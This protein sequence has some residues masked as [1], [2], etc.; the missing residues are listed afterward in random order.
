MDDETGK[1]HRREDDPL[2]LPDMFPSSASSSGKSGGRFASAIHSL[3]AS[4]SSL[5]FW[6]RNGASD[7]SS[8]EGEGNAGSKYGS[9][10][11]VPKDGRGDGCDGGSS[12]D[13]DCEIESGTGGRNGGDG[14]GK[15]LSFIG[16]L[17]VCYFLVCGGAYGTEDLASSIPPLFAL[18]GLLVLPWFWSL[19]IALIVAELGSALPS[20]EGFL[21]WIRKAWGEGAAFIDGWIMIITIII[22]QSLY[23]VIFISY[24]ES[25]EELE[26]IQEFAISVGYIVLAMCL[27]LL[28]VS[29]VGN[30]STV[31]TCLTLVPFGIYFIAGFFSDNFDASMWIQTDMTNG[32]E[33]DIALYLSVLV[34]ATCAYE[35]SGFLAGDVRNPRKVF[36]IAMFSVVTMMIVTY[37]LPMAMTIATA[38]HLD[39]VT[40]GS[41]PDLAKDLGVGDWMGWCIVI[42]G[43]AST[44]GTYITY[45]HTSST[46]VRGLASQGMAPAIFNALPQFKTPI[47]GI[48]FFSCTTVV[49]VNFEF[50]VLIQIESFLYCVHAI[51]LV[52]CLLRLRIKYPDLDRPFS[53]PLGWFGAVII[54]IFPMIVG[55][56]QIGSIFW[57][58]W[59]YALIAIGLLVFGVLTYLVIKARSQRRERL[60]REIAAAHGSKIVAKNDSTYAHGI[61]N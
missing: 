17:S 5:F 43:L 48:V 20:S 58:D 10:R 30:A 35:Y 21:G 2:I 1:A 54:P 42:G 33:W 14:D 51:L 45:L 32:G 8:D 25:I 56:V 47:V 36:P 52:S 19:P 11:G 9:E 4:D 41:Y 44:M 15:K 40:E 24:V 61:G 12:A 37:L 39:Q 31:L 16:L 28:G 38:K 46:A 13:E 7:G 57:E 22:D 59:V 23:P 6:R 27:N 55:L 49:I 3:G 53:L 26:P 18:L 50:N 60:Q 34:W 29:S